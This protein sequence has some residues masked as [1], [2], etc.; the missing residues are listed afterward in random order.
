VTVPA[1]ENKAPNWSLGKA[2]RSKLELSPVLA[3]PLGQ[4]RLSG[5]IRRLHCRS[6]RGGIP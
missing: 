5:Q 3:R 4:D 2:A 1:S 6:V